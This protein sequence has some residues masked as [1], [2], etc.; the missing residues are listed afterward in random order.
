MIADCLFKVANLAIW[1]GTQSRL[2]SFTHLRTISSEALALFITNSKGHVQTSFRKLEP[3]E[4][5]LG[6]ISCM[7]VLQFFAYIEN[8]NHFEK[9]QMHHLSN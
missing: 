8:S 6:F 5:N 7:N 4:H 1:K 3:C 2:T 9:K